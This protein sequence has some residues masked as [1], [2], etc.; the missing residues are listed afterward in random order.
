[1]LSSSPQ[2]VPLLAPPAPK[3]EQKEPITDD[4]KLQKSLAEVGDAQ[5]SLLS[6]YEKLGI[7]LKDKYGIDVSDS[8]KAL[9]IES[10]KQKALTT[11]ALAKLGIKD[12]AEEEVKQTSTSP[13]G[14][15]DLKTGETVPADHPALGKV[16]KEKPKGYKPKVTALN[17]NGK[18][19]DAKELA[20]ALRNHLK[21]AG[22]THYTIFGLDH[23]YKKTKGLLMNIKIT[24][25]GDP[26]LNL[27]KWALTG[28]QAAIVTLRVP[29][30]SV[31]LEF[32]SP[33]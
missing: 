6:N 26:E 20:D 29:F 24:W 1:M 7:L 19:V 22:F 28:N 33:A 8:V 14:S 3:E 17:I 12:Q 9:V 21:K 31:P 23:H 5:T 30:Q 4:Q 2:P 25:A 10:Q 16:K 11:E 32:Q 27:I 18:T 13:L 15:I